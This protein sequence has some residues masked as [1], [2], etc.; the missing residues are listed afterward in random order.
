MPH[1]KAYGK[2]SPSFSFLALASAGSS[3]F[4]G[5][6]PASSAPSS[7]SLA[8]F[9]DFFLV[10]IVLGLDDLLD[11]LPFLSP[12]SGA[13]GVV[14]FNL[15]AVFGVFAGYGPAVNKQS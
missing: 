2:I 11:S 4:A 8:V 1:G 15:V 12:V 3:G 14:S 6:L 9:L 10:G 5:L 7:S 13:L